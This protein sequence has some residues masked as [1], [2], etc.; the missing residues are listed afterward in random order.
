MSWKNLAAHDAVD[1]RARAGADLLALE[2][3]ERLNA[4]A[5]F[6][7]DAAGAAG[8][9]DRRN[10][11]QFADGGAD[12]ERRAADRRDIQTIGDK[13]VAGVLAGAEAFGVDLDTVFLEQIELE[14]HHR[15]RSPQAVLIAEPYDIRFG[16]GGYEQR[17]QYQAGKSQR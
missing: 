15:G 17:R 16:A 8:I 14:R 12:H 13:A 9:G 4:A 11:V 2:L 7:F 6:Y 5:F 1:G 3:I 10:R